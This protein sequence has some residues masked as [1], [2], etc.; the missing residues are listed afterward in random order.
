[1][2]LEIKLLLLILVFELAKVFR[3]V[4]RLF[5]VYCFNEII[6][7]GVLAV[8]LVFVTS[9]LLDDLFDFSLAE[10]FFSL[11]EIELFEHTLHNV[12]YFVCHFYLINTI[13]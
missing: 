5:I 10:E 4:Q 1:M 3:F 6:D 7:L 13:F 8:H 11:I 12:V 9:A 2:V